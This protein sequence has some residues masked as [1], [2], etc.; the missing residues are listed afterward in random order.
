MPRKAAL[1]QSAVMDSSNSSFWRQ[2]SK[3]SCTGEKKKKNNNNNNTTRT[4]VLVLDT[5][6]WGEDKY[7]RAEHFSSSL[8]FFEKTILP[9]YLYFHTTTKRKNKN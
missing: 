4:T 2:D 1:T 7:V 6:Q 5:N 8:T 9:P 3:Y